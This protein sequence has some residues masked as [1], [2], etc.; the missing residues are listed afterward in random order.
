MA[1]LEAFRENSSRY[2]P[3]IDPTIQTAHLSQNDLADLVESLDYSRLSTTPRRKSQ[4]GTSES[5][6]LVSNLPSPFFDD[7]LN[8]L[9]LSNTSRPGDM[10]FSGM[11]A[12][13][14]DFAVLPS[15]PSA[16]AKIPSP[17]PSGMTNNRV[18]AI[19]TNA[20]TSNIQFHTNVNGASNSNNAAGPSNHH[21]PR[22]TPR[23]T[24]SQGSGSSPKSYSHHHQEQAF[25]QYLQQQQQRE[26]THAV[27]MPAGPVQ[28]SPLEAT[29][30]ASSYLSHITSPPL[31]TSTSTS[32]PTANPPSNSAIDRNIAASVNNAPTIS[33]SIH[34]GATSAQQRASYRRLSASNT[35][36]RRPWY[37]QSQAPEDIVGVFGDPGQM[38]GLL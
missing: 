16:P 4:G 10:Y 32:N 1:R 38:A 8:L 31:L 17:P 11:F 22:S 3:L 26:P 2:A 21:S 24:F 14:E 9:P 27:P 18:T 13:D 25:P 34:E 33:G 37:E 20:D 7:F 15:D 6:P 30:H 36:A 35:G 28:F 29:S 5:H 19:P 12:G 23:T